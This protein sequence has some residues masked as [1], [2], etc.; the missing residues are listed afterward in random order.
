MCKPNLVKHF[1]QRFLLFLCL[2]QAKILKNNTLSMLIFLCQ[3]L[4]STVHTVTWSMMTIITRVLAPAWFR[5]KSFSPAWHQPTKLERD[6]PGGSCSA[7]L[8]SGRTHYTVHSTHIPSLRVN[9]ARTLLAPVQCALRC[10]VTVEDTVSGDN[11]WQ[12][13]SRDHRLFASLVSEQHWEK[14]ETVLNL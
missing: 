1:G 9:P 10:T 14:R 7:Y 12:E 4:L 11:L 3:L 5:I 13:S 8:L 2:C 6:D